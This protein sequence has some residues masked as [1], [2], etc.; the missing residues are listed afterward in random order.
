MRPDASSLLGE[1]PPGPG[2]QPPSPADGRAWIAV[3]PVAVVVTVIIELG[4]FFA[5]KGQSHCPN[6]LIPADCRRPFDAG[7]AILL[8]VAGLALLGRRR[9][10][11]AT[12]ATVFGAVLVYQA[13]GYA[14][15]PIWLP[16]VIAY[17]G[18]IV[19]G[20]RLVV[21]CFAVAGFLI[22][23]WLDDVLRDGPAPSLS[24]LA[25][26]AAWLL[27]LLGLGEILRIRRERFAQAVQIREEEARRRA[28]EERLRIAR[29]LHDA[30]GHHLSLISV[31]AGVA[32]HVNEQLPEEV[33]G[34]LTAIKQASKEALTELRSVLDI[35]RQ[36]GERAPR[37]PTSTL[38]RL[39][40]L[41]TQAA[42]AGIEVRTETD[43][44][45][46]PLPFGVDVAAFRIVQE[47]LTNV[48][49]HAGSASATV[50]L[51]YGEHDLTVQ[52]DDDGRGDSADGS[53]GTG[54]GLVGMRERATA[55]GGDLEAGP[56]PEGGYRVRARLPLE[57]VG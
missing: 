2:D 48:A 18:A 30:L 31:Q 4:S 54:Q 24:G 15:G 39:D 6:P 12:L 33:S 34:S 8:L 56:R 55:L 26:L 3:V 16:L 45:E 35:L 38:A 37:S 5:S 13:M 36:D 1:R 49:R 57:P 22:F 21:A 27:V 51:A 7:A 14:N 43:G 20:H 40:D 53:S 47:A 19:Q 9:Y 52:V 32:L 44:P 41:V 11:V 17:I 23:P 46:H 50:R 29:E 10:P 42:A 28:S 25:G